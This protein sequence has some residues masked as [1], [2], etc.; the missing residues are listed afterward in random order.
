MT[1]I[2]LERIKDQLLEEGLYCKIGQEIHKFKELNSKMLT[3]GRTRE[4]ELEFLNAANIIIENIRI[5]S[6]ERFALELAIRARK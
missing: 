1:N 4:T 3:V 6:N 5:F 2:E